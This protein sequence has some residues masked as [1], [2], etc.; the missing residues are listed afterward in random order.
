MHLQI[1]YRKV[2]NWL[3]TGDLDI[4]DGY[5]YAAVRKA[6]EKKE[7]VKINFYSEEEEKQIAEKRT[8]SS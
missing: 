4:S 8:R 5:V 3:I 6:T 7:T 1:L 2:M